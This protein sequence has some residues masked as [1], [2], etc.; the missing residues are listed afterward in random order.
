MPFT[1]TNTGN[2]TLTNVTV[3]DPGVTM[4]GGPIA[5]L[6]PGAV[7]NATF[8]ASYIIYSGRH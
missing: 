6:A 1:V 8:T 7:D 2:V 4:L 3:T 5:S